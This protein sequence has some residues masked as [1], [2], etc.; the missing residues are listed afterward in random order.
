MTVWLNGKIVPPDE[1]KISAFDAGLQ[2]GVGLFET[3]LAR[4]GEVFRRDAHLQR[5]ADSARSLRLT[6]QL[7]LRPLGE[8][9]RMALATEQ[10]SGEDNELRRVRLTLTGGDLNLLMREHRPNVDP[11]ILIQVQPA[12]RYPEQLM[13]RGARAVIADAKS[14]PLDPMA[15]HKT[16]DYWGRLTALQD[17]AAKQADE[18][19]WLMVT[20]HVASGSVS[21]L[22]IVKDGALLTPIA[23]GEEERGGMPSPVLPGVTRAVI[24][25]IAGSVGIGS[26]AQMLTIDELLDADEVFLTNSSWGVM[27]IVQVEAKAI[28]DG[29]PGPVT[30]DLG[31]RYWRLFEEETVA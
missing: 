27:P 5:L 28:G 23:Q 12:T 25:E 13:E 17:A 31:E 8:A 21:N 14:N 16:L 1:A 2:H 20:N 10:L 24:R 29:Y 3:M 7:H 11:T 19:I 15:G 26:S 22:F 18:A 4:G 30:K 6:D 9:I